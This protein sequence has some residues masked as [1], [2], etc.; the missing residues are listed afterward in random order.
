LGENVSFNEVNT[1]S[2]FETKYIELINCFKSDTHHLVIC[3]TPFFPSQEKNEIIGRVALATHSYLADLS[4]LPLIDKQNCAK[5]EM[6]YTGDKTLWKV[7]GIGIHPGDYGMRNIAMEIF[8]IINAYLDKAI[9]NQ[10]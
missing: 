4:H 7:T 1:P 9:I 2:L 5:D 3:T 10:K 6:N 8:I